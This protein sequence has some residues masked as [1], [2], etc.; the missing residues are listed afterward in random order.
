V[1][2]C[3]LNAGHVLY[4]SATGSGLAV[5]DIVWEAFDRQYLP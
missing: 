4:S 1:T 3:T 5:P 2:Q